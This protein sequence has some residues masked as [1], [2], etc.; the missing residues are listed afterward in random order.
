VDGFDP[1]ILLERLEEDRELFVKIM[2]VFLDDVPKQMGALEEALDTG[3]VKTVQFQTHT[4][5]GSA[6][7]VGATSMQDVV[8]KMEK[9]AKEGDLEQT[10]ILVP[11]LTQE[12]ERIKNSLLDGLPPTDT[13]GAQ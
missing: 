9:A 13:E 1:T 10:R 6:G 11:E 12:F 8:I 7:H 5:K 4:L 2:I 3:D